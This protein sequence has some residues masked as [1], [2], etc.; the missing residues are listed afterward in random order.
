MDDYIINK[1]NELKKSISTDLITVNLYS[2]SDIESQNISEETQVKSRCECYR[3]MVILL[4]LSSI[5][6]L[7]LTFYYL[8]TS[9]N[10]N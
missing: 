10:H 7:I 9:L 6:I 2:S 4:L 3:I 5:T 1:E 8:L